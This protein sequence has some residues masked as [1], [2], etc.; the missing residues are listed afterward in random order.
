M[1]MSCAVS[2]RSRGSATARARSQCR[3][4]GIAI[5]LLRWCRRPTAAFSVLPSATPSRSDCLSAPIAPSV[6]C[7]LRVRRRAAR[8]IPIQ[9]LAPIAYFFRSLISAVGF[10]IM[11]ARRY[12]DHRPPKLKSIVSLWEYDRDEADLPSGRSGFYAGRRRMHHP[13]HAGRAEGRHARGRRIPGQ[14]GR[15]AAS[16]RPDEAA[17]AKPVRDTCEKRPEGVPVFGSIRLQLRLFRNAAELGRIPAATGCPADGPGGN[18][19]SREPGRMGFRSLGLVS[20]YTARGLP[21]AFRQSSTTA[22]PAGTTASG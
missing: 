7:R 1:S 11:R 15:L 20:R 13:A 5:S 8:T 2:K 3:S 14:E 22:W 19:G 16:R 21:L 9:Y 17:A 18:L 12:N 6:R 10:V 4:T